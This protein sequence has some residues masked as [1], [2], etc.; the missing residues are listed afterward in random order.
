MFN[1]NFAE[2]LTVIRPATPRRRPNAS[3]S[4]RDTIQATVAESTSAVTDHP[5]FI[6]PITIESSPTPIPA[7]VEHPGNA[8]RASVSSLS[9][10]EDPTRASIDTNGDR[11][12]ESPVTVRSQDRRSFTS[13]LTGASV[14]G[15][16][17]TM[18]FRRRSG[19]VA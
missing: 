18:S 4:K 5:T 9:P 19:E 12:S 17:K 15:I 1:K 14:K 6:P 2:E 3:I 7:S 11:S 13:R 8:A 16:R 10:Y